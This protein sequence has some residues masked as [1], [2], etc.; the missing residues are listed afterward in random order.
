MTIAPDLSTLTGI[1]AFETVALSERLKAKTTYDVIVRSARDFPKRTAIVFT[2]DGQPDSPEFRMTY[3]EVLEQIHATANAF[4]ALGVGEHDAVS[5]L[6]PN[7]P[8]YPVGLFAAEAV[9]IASPINPFL[10]VAEIVDILNTVNAK[11]LVTTA[12]ELNAQIWEKALIAAKSVPSLTAIVCVET[13]GLS[14]AMAIENLEE[15]RFDVIGFCEILEHQPKDVLIAHRRP[16]P[17]SI[18]A[19]FH[20]GGTTGSPKIAPHTHINQVYVGFAV[21]TGDGSNEAS[22]N[23]LLNGL[24]FFHVNAVIIGALNP[25]Y[26]GGTMVLVSV[27]GFR[28]RTV[29]QNFWSLVARF[30]ATSTTVVPTVLSALCDIPTGGA[31]ISSMRYVICGAAP[32]A[33]EILKRFEA[34]TG[35]RVLEGYGLTEGACVSTRNPFSGQSKPGSVGQRLPYQELKI[36]LLHED[37]SFASECEQNEIG[38]VLVKGPNIF[39]GYLKPEHN[40]GIFAKDGWFNTGDMGR[41]D[42]DGFLW[43]TGRSKDLIIRGGHNIDPASIEEVLL[44]YEKVQ[45]AAAIGKPDARVG[46][47]PVA[48]VSLKPGETATEEEILQ[49]AQ[50]SIRERAAIP[51]Q[52][53]ILDAIPV[54]AVGKIFKPSLRERVILQTI[55]QGLS[56]IPIE[57]DVK[58]ARD[59]EG[60]MSIQVNCQTRDDIDRAKAALAPFAL[61]FRFETRETIDI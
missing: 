1:E 37:G 17:D 53:T 21:S 25:F 35:I 49:Y 36:A 60:V 51:T 39:P 23:V 50:S 24:P 58:I 2:R 29:V 61:P 14:P 6:L 13:D 27:D 38:A 32:L 40:A 33:P 28:N 20:T 54:T 26:Y 55:R 46:E 9:A 56:D 4:S 16:R 7:L 3:E 30:G 31:K 45:L 52:V 11:V 18:A 41:I 42:R 12:P 34:H 5:F 59:D 19:Y 43:L 8:A 44:K 48:F 47:V 10:E 22:P 15:T 57:A